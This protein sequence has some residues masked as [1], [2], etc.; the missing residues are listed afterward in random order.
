MVQSLKKIEDIYHTA[1]DDIIGNCAYKWF[2]QINDLHSAEYLS[3]T[4]GKT[5]IQVM[6]KGENK[7]TSKSFGGSG[8]SASSS[9]GDNVSYSE[10]GRDLLTPDE[11]ITL[12]PDYAI[13]LTPDPGR[14]I[15]G[16]LIIG[17][18]RRPSLIC[19]LPVQAFTGRLIS[20]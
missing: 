10:T 11:V 13:L 5:T 4:L 6:T 7:G 20:I 2:C 8:G 14:T 18:C 17:V 15:C 16:P 19:G 12:G 1:A 9:E 3:K